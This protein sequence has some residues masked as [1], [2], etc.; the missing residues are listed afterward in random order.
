MPVVA[1]AVVARSA[2]VGVGAAVIGR[3]IIARSVITVAWAIGIAWIGAGREA[4]ADY[5]RGKAEAQR[6]AEAG[7]PQDEKWG[8]WPGGL[9][10]S[11]LFS[12]HMVNSIWP[13]GN[14]RQ[15]STLLM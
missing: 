3:A 8:A 12:R 2:V 7:A 5:A 15:L 6:R 13:S 9:V 14:S 11:A 10:Q 4:C 1:M